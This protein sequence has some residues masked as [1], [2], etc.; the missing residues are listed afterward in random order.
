MRQTLRLLTSVSLVAS[1]FLTADA[2]TVG[3][4]RNGVAGHAKAI[5]DLNVSATG[6]SPE[7]FQGMLIPRM[8]AAQRMAIAGL[9]A[10]DQGLWVFQTDDAPNTSGDPTLAGEFASGYWYYEGLV[11]GAPFF[12]WV[13]WSTGGSSWRLTGNANT[14]AT[15][16]YLGTP[17]AS[18]DD[19]YIRTTNNLTPNPSIRINATDGFVGMNLAAA[20]VERVEV[21]GGVQV[22]NTTANNVGSI[23]YE[24]GA[25]TPATPNKWHYGNVNGLATGWQRM[26]NAE[27]RYINQAYCP[28]VQQCG[29]VDGNLVKGIYDGSPVASTP[30]AG[31]MH[32]PFMTNTGANNRQG[33]RVQY[34]YPGTEL[35]AAGLC[36]GFITKFSFYV[37]QNEPACTPNVNCPDVKI[38]IRMGNTAL[39]TFGPVVNSSAVPTTVN[40]DAPTEASAQIYATSTL[41]ELISTGWK[42]FDLNGAGFNWTG[43]NLIIDVS[44]QRATTIGNSPQVQLEEALAYGATKWVQVTTSFNPAHGNTY[45]DNPLTANATCGVTNTRP[46][47][48]F[49]GKV[50]SPGYGAVT[51][52]AYL[53]YGGGLMIDHNVNPTTWADGAYRGPGTI[54]ASLGVYD[55]NT[56]L[57]DHVFDRYYDGDV[58]PEDARSAEDYAY[59]GLPELKSYLEQERHLPNMPSREEWELHGTRSLGELQTGLW[60]SVETQALY[61]TELENDL[62]ALESLAFGKLKSADEINQLI[63]D[64]QKSRRL[65][66]AQK[67]HLTHAL[68]ARLSAQPD[69]K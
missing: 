66:E 2:Q 58:K 54:R 69:T 32:T 19:L 30:V 5:L 6:A 11:P 36:P 23:R 62:S 1:V 3:I 8:T 57:S 43:G 42:D 16:N 56:Q 13:R 17:A 39:A 67:L 21:N 64:V 31:P 18:N 22:G 35:L 38:D 12:G 28:I 44:W 60:E 68:Q 27:T 15:T 65:T 37:L 24:T 47:T 4:N 48:R 51:N 61:I 49:Y 7:H 50:A 63:G 29:N 53:N 40:W 41:A 45:Q 52:G 33:Y 20:P 55:G 9:T 59:V 14:V 25:Y 10:A 26:E 46:V 34:I